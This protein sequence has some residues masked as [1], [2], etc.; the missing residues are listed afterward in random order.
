VHPYKYEK[1]VGRSPKARRRAAHEVQ[2][3][4]GPRLTKHGVTIH[5]KHYENLVIT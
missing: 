4:N 1:K 2:G 3:A 5:Y